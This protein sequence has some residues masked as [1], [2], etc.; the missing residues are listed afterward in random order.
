[1]NWNMLTP[2]WQ[3]VFELCW[4]AFCEG[5][6]PIAA[7]ITDQ[8]G[9]ILS[10]GKNN[11]NISHKFLNS[12]V[13]HAETECVQM[14]DAMK[15]PDLKSY[16]LY[17][18]ME[19]C[20]MC[21]GTIVMGNLRKVRIASRDPWAGAADLRSQNEYIASKNMEIEFVEDDWGLVSMTLLVYSERR[22]DRKRNPFLERVKETFPVAV[23]AADILYKDR[24]LDNYRNDNRPMEEIFNHIASVFSTLE[25]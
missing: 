7:I 19:P 4:E 10:T 1:M 11:L 3:K 15:Y 22:A 8:E 14:L 5:N 9:N 18:S 13:D 12:R 17:T 25:D 2:E 16:I 6:L 23:S 24:E 21:M 20:P